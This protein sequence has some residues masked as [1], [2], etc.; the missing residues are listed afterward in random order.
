MRNKAAAVTTPLTEEGTKGRLGAKREA[1]LSEDNHHPDR[2]VLSVWG[3]VGKKAGS[4]QLK[5]TDPSTNW[6]KCFF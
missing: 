3:Q 2:E 6:S 5:G 4:S 1:G